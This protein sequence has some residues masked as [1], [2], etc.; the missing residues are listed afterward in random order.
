MEKLWDLDHKKNIDQKNKHARY[1]KI[2]GRSN[3]ITLINPFAL[4]TFGIASIGWIITFAG[5]IATNTQNSLF[6]KFAWW[7]VV[8]QLLLLIVIVVFYITNTFQYHRLFLTCSI[9][10][11]FVYNSNAANNL[12]YDSDSAPGAASAGFIIQCI[13]NILWMLYFGSEPSSPIISYIDSFG[14]GSNVMLSTRRSKSNRNTMNQTQPVYDETYKE[15]NTGYLDRNSLSNDTTPAHENPFN[16]NYSSQLNGLEN[17]SASNRAS[18]LHEEDY[19]ITVRGLFDYEASP[20]DINELSFKKGD[21]FRVKDTVGNWWQGKN[22][23][24]EI[25]MCPS[26][27]LEVIG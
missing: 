25:G 17:A 8:Y 12:V 9:G 1:L 6:P 20:D 23:K 2:M 15:E 22:S 4:S 24:G 10:V 18:A 19:P 5:C 7:A 21:V 14:N 13:I 3:P 26:N 16:Q 11:A 27:Y